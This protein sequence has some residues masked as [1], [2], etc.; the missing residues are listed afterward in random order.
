ME[1]T[2]KSKSQGFGD[3]DNGLLFEKWRIFRR[4]TDRYGVYVSP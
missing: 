3:A 1:I 2:K 4:E